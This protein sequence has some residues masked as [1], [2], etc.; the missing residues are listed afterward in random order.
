MLTSAHVRI[1]AQTAAGTTVLVAVD[2]DELP[3]GGFGAVLYDPVRLYDVRL[4]TL[5]NPLWLGSALKFLGG[6]LEHPHLD[7]REA[8]RTLARVAELMPVD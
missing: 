6:Y 3:V 4:D 8:E 1:I 7:E 2:G 5:S